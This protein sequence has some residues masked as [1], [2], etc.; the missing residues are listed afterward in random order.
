MKRLIVII[1]S[2]IVILI[3]CS[4]KDNINRPVVSLKRVMIEG[5]GGGGIPSSYTQYTW[6][7]PTTG[8]AVAR[9]IGE[10][11]IDYGDSRHYVLADVGPDTTYGYN[12]I[13][14]FKYRFRVAGIDAET[15][16]GVMSEWSE[17]LDLTGGV[18]NDNEM[19]Q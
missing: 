13:K 18:E 5:S 16:Q 4:D 14:G 10:I 19:G 11:E 3:G 6:T 12:F 9:Y 1:L 8:T 2:L 17:V 7:A 15:R